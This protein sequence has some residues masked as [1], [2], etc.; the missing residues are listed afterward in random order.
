MRVKVKRPR[1]K[2][3]IPARKGKS[4]GHRKARHKAILTRVYHRR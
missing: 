1:Y 4:Y 2:T 3:L